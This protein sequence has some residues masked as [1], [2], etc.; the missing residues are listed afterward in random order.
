MTKNVCVRSILEGAFPTSPNDHLHEVLLIKRRITSDIYS[1]MYTA[2]YTI[3]Y[4]IIL[5]YIMY[6][7]CSSF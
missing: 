3:L 6:Y 4:H 2:V 1:H 7:I 5:Y